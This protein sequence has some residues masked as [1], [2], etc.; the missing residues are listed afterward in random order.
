MWHRFF[1]NSAILRS[2]AVANCRSFRVTFVAWPRGTSFFSFAPIFEEVPQILDCFDDLIGFFLGLLL[3]FV[4]IS[5]CSL[6]RWTKASLPVAFITTQQANSRDATR[7]KNR[8]TT[9]DAV[10]T[11]H[12]RAPR[13]SKHG[14]L[15]ASASASS[16]SGDT[17]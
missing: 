16:N 7:P 9:S 2:G 11:R 14:F 6:V 4:V 10:L 8:P 5:L 12:P 17:S 15:D 13:L 3:C 1:R